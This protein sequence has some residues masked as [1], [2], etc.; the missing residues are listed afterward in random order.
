[1]FFSRG[2]KIISDWLTIHVMPFTELCGT[3][4]H[5]TCWSSSSIGRGGPDDHQPYCYLDRGNGKYHVWSS[6]NVGSYGSQMGR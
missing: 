3:G 5:G 6:T 4:S 2:A 1:M